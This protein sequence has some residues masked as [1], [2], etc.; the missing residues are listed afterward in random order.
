MRAIGFTEHGGPEVLRFVEVPE[1]RPGPKDLVVRVHAAGVN[2]VDAKVRAGVRGGPLD[3]PRVPGWDASGV[4]EAAGPECRH[5]PGDEVF[6]AGDIGRPGSYA[7]KV[8]VDERLVGPKPRSLT[9][10]EA[11]AMPLTT[12]TAWEAFLECMGA[13]PEAYGESAPSQFRMAPVRGL[14]TLIVG[15]GGGVGSIAIQVATR[16]CGLSVAATASR[17]DSRAFCESMGARAVLDHAR[18][19]RAQTDALGLKGYD[20]ILSTVDTRNLPE[21]SDLLNPAGSLCYIVPPHGPLDLS[22]FFPKR[23]SL[24]F[25][26]MF[27][28]ARHDAQ[29]ERQGLILRRAS[30]LLDEGVLKTTLTRTLPWTDF[31]EAHRR[32]DSGR[33]VGKIVLEIA[34]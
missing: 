28:R 21:M 34:R 10:A 12:L 31:A 11:A 8:A 26:L 3:G 32:I 2:P 27:A 16:V 23:A 30:R 17:P 1:P 20:Y 18:N 25:E 15:G 5:K 7:E 6:F 14:D 19:L 13:P 22:A 4:V 9:H 24:S 29:P 33:T